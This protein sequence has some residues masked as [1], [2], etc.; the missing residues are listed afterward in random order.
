M[1]E[2]PYAMVMVGALLVAAVAAAMVSWRFAI[3]V[4]PFSWT[5]EADRL[6]DL[7]RLQPGSVVA[8]IGAGDGTLAVE[9][10]RRVGESG[11][12]YATELSA[13]RRRDI[14]ALVARAGT[15][16]VRVVAASNDATHL[17]DQCCDAIYLRTVLHH[18]VDREAL[19]GDIRRALRPNGRLA[20]IDFPPGALWFHGRN[21]GVAAQEATQAFQ[22]GG[23]TPTQ[24]VGKWGGG[25]YLLLFEK[26]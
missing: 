25:T 6:A 26:M 22:K 16:R 20:I 11:V 19:A 2:K 14:E 7:L 4:M 21:H 1:L 9:M 23:L 3:F 18:I 8:D 10:V 15:P 12:V 17:P 13:E 5:G 24:S